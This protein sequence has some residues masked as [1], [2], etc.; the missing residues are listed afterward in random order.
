MNDYTVIKIYS[1][2]KQYYTPEYKQAIF[3]LV[4][5]WSNR[6]ECPLAQIPFEILLK[7]IVISPDTHFSDWIDDRNWEWIWT[8][9]DLENNKLKS[10]PESFG[11]LPNLTKLH[12]PN[13]TKLRLPDNNLKPFSPNDQITKYV[14]N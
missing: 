13:L 8:R 11:I 12:L 5:I 10:P 4:C 3:T 2:Q 9:S 7:I 14:V 6:P 1:K